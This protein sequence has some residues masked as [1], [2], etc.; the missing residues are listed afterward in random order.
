M[1]GLLVHCFRRL[2]NVIQRWTGILTPGLLPLPPICT[3]TCCTYNSMGSHSPPPIN[4]PHGNWDFENGDWVVIHVKRRPKE[5]TKS[6]SILVA[7]LGPSSDHLVH[8]ECFANENWVILSL[9]FHFFLPLPFT[10]YWKTKLGEG[11]WHRGN[12]DKPLWVQQFTC[13][14]GHALSGT[15]GS[16]FIRNRLIRNWGL[17]ELFSL[18]YSYLSCVN[19]PT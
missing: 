4:T 6:C 18:S 14:C 5:R 11:V 3:G 13:W 9:N 17:S 2:W 10:G 15:G 12:L 8:R 7:Y 19:L 16:R 1:V